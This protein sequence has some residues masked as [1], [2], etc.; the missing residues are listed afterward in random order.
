MLQ[1]DELKSA[2]LLVFANKQDMP[3]AVSA[4]D[5]AKRLGLHQLRNREWYV[6][7]SSAHSGEGL[8]EGMDWLCR[9]LQHSS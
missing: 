6:Q 5:V 9:K 3:K 1:S 8:F 4:Q 2:H 7:P